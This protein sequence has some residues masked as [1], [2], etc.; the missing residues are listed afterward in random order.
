MP[1]PGGG[2]RPGRP[3]KGKHEP[4]VLDLA[5]L[6]GI[7]LD[8]HH[9]AVEIYCRDA[10]LVV[11]VDA[12]LDVG[13]LVCEEQRVEV[14]DFAPMHV[15]DPAR[16][17]ADVFELGEDGDQRVGGSLLDTARSADATGAPSDDDDP[18]RHGQPLSDRA[19]RE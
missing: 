17:V 7:L 9:L 10:R 8:L 15:R 14:F 19:T 11:D 4:V 2:Y 12:G 18:K 3:Y 6:A 16:A 13:L 1:G 5:S